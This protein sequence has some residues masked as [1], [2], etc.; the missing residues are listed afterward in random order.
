[1]L[2]RDLEWADRDHLEWL[3]GELQTSADELADRAIA[4]DVLDCAAPFAPGG[5]PTQGEET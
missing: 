1:M 5:D 3:A 2:A 4:A